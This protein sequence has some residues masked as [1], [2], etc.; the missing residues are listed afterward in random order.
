MGWFA[1]YK[2]T[3][4]IAAV[5][6][7]IDL[8]LYR[9]LA[10][11]LVKSVYRTKITPDHL[12]YSAL[13]AGVA[14]GIFYSLGTR[15][16][17]LVAACLYFF[18]IVL[19]CSDGQLARLKGNGTPVGRILDG[20][21][22]Y[23]AAIAVYVGIASGYAGK[24]GEPSYMILLLALSGASIIF[25]EMLVDYHRTHFID[26]IKNRRNTFT[27]VN[28]EFRQEY[29]RLK[30]SRDKWLEKNII[31]IYLLYSNLQKKLLP[32]RIKPNI[33]YVPSDIYFKKNRILIRLWILMG[34]SAVKTTLILCSIFDRFDI[35]L[36]VTIV[37]LNIF[38]IIMLIIQRITDNSYYRSRQNGISGASPQDK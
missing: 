10:F 6:E 33:P 13:I 23:T 32:K 1:E 7:Y 15:D 9:P 27:V 34:P 20:I 30:H 31:Y 28:L 14:A 16:T 26:I 19:D 8:F 36:W 18:F 22:D 17:S 38:A 29:L 24:E 21:A 12:T 2:K 5:E 37:G 4:K 35:Y 25:Q 11:L 3:L